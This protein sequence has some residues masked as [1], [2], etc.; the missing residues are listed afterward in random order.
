[1]FKYL[2]FV[3]IVFWG[4]SPVVLGQGGSVETSFSHV[5]PS[6][7]DGLEFTVRV[8]IK[9]HTIMF[10][11]PAYNVVAKKEKG[12]RVHYQ[13]KV[14][15]RSQVGEEVWKK[16]EVGTLDLAADIYD[17]SYKVASMS[18][19]NVISFDISGSPNWG[20]VFPGLSAEEEKALFKKGLSIKNVRVERAATQ[21][22]Y[23][24]ESWIKKNGGETGG[25]AQ[26]S[27]GSGSGSAGSGS[28]V[29]S[30]SSV[31]DVNRQRQAAQQKSNATQQKSAAQQH[32]EHVNKVN[33]GNQERQRKQAEADAQAK[34]R[35]E[36]QQQAEIRKR[37]AAYEAQQRK[38][39]EEARKR[40][41]YQQWAQQQTQ[42]NAAAAAGAAAGAAGLAY[43]LGTIIY[44]GMGNVDPDNA[45]T[46]D[47][48]FYVGQEIGYSVYVQPM[49]YNSDVFDGVSSRTKTQYD[50]TFPINLDYKLKM[51]ME[52]EY[53]GFNGFGRISVGMSPLISHFQFPGYAYGGQVY[54][55]IRNAKAFFEY[56]AESRTNNIDYWILAD[57]SGFGRS[58][59]KT[60]NIKYGL[61]FSWGQYVRSH[62]NLGVINEAVLPG[63]G[64][65]VQRLEHLIPESNTQPLSEFYESMYIP[66]Y[67]FEYRKDHSFNFFIHVYPEYPFS[68]EV[69]YTLDSKAAEKYEKGFPFIWVGFHRA[70][71]FYL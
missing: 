19:P 9:Y 29:P 47:V 57:E 1:M 62:I 24:L 32:Q 49:Y 58:V 63:D 16:L 35:R 17:G 30:A 54:S 33:A 64:S 26:A 52:S 39:R 5:P 40:Q 65:R 66:G 53:V 45:Y 71:D 4:F 3:A 7:E 56:S 59:V 43:L 8:K 21:G 50:F 11:E 12:D 6:G 14:Y 41:E 10:G 48:S 2:V 70:I 60:Q 69:E 46:G 27:S 31:E 42:Q 34:R 25:S 37:Q 68:G 22:M 51:G 61:R 23:A 36:A 13:G 20:D 44:G 15:A 38:Q 55:G 18:Y 28:P 67:F